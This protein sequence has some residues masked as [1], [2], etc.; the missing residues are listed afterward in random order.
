MKQSE[1]RAQGRRAGVPPSF[2][3][4]V[5]EEPEL[6]IKPSGAFHVVVHAEVVPDGVSLERLHESIRATTASA[7][8]AGYADAFA[9]M[10]E[11]DDAAGGQPVDRPGSADGGALPG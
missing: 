11:T 7:V 5:E 10:D 2:G 9:R 4:P 3:R 8:L 6:T 1:Q